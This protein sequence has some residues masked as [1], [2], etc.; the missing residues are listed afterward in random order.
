MKGIISL[1]FILILGVGYAAPPPC[2]CATT[3]P[4]DFNDITIWDCGIVPIKSTDVT[5]S[6][7][8]VLNVSFT[9]GDK[10][11]GDWVVDAGASL[12]GTAFSLEFGGGT[13]EI[14]GTFSINNLSINNGAELTFGATANVTI[15]G[16]LTNDNNSDEVVVNTANF[17]VLGALTNGNGSSITGIGC[18]TVTG[19]ITN[20]E[21]GR[22]F[23]CGTF[24][25]DGVGCDACA[26]A[27]LIEM[28]NFSVENIDN[29]A[30][31]FWETA[32]E[33]NNQEFIIEKSENGSQFEEIGRLNGA[34]TSFVPIK[35][36]YNDVAELSYG[37]T[38]YR[39][40]D[41]DRDNFK[42]TNYAVPVT[43]TIL[44]KCKV[45][46]RETELIISTSKDVNYI[47]YSMVGQ[48]L[49]SGSILSESSAVLTTRDI[50]G[51]VFLSVF[52]STFKPIETIKIAIN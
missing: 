22:L 50:K 34:G 7:A 19:T 30:H 27:L 49:T 46:V 4:G 15:N 17:D 24:N 29:T 31:L 5:I 37:V 44:E 33:I 1:L 20:H 45:Q 48:R 18:L 32:S 14:N 51:V 26:A 28:T 43:S 38:Y 9:D 2:C 41:V 47:L 6:H 36:E 52:D 12:I 40:I 8:V 25:D 21:D 39:L 13:S 23:D 16:D 42:T 3:G 35:Y 10:I 11:S